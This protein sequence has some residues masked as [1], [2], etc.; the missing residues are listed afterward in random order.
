MKIVILGAGALG[1]LIGAHLARAG[2]EV[3][4][5]ARGERAKFLREHGI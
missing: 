4:L 2:E 5:I 1:S 3:T